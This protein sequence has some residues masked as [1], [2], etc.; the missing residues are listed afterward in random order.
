MERG[1]RRR[2]AWRQGRKLGWK[3]GER[4][5]QVQGREPGTG[6]GDGYRRGDRYREGDRH[7]EGDWYRR[8]WGRWIQDREMGT[9]R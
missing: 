3:K 5:R 1:W 8:G 4:G 7:P 6:E 2:E 9:R